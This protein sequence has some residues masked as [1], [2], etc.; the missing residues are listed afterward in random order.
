MFPQVSKVTFVP[1]C[2]LF[3]SYTLDYKLLVFVTFCT[4][5]EMCTYISALRPVPQNFIHMI[6]HTISTSDPVYG[7]G[8]GVLS[9]D[10]QKGKHPKPILHI[11]PHLFLLPLL[12]PFPVPLS[13]WPAHFM[14]FQHP[15]PPQHIC[16]YGDRKRLAN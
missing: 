2:M 7:W 15:P 10:N 8:W 5:F 13:T 12:P 4:T 3:I 11:L 6:Q 1:S 16:T 9:N 14:Q